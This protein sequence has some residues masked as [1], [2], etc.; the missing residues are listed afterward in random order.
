M[1]DT[2]EIKWELW[3][4]V[5]G[6]WDYIKNSDEFEDVDDLT[7]EWVGTIPGKRESRRF[8]GLYMLKQ[9]DLVESLLSVTKTIYATKRI[10]AGNWKNMQVAS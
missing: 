8:E 2:E 4:V 3:K 9:Q 7:L 5:Y 6:V 1:H 10:T